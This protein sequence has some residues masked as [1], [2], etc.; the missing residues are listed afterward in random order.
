VLP[1]RLALLQV[2]QVVDALGMMFMVVIN[3]CVEG[4]QL[5]VGCISRIGV[6]ANSVREKSFIFNNGGEGGI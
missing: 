2:T 4:L 6:L 3:E 5:A 1:N